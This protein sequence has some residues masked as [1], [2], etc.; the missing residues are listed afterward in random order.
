MPDSAVPLLV[1]CTV[2]VLEPPQGARPLLEELGTTLAVRVTLCP[3]VMLEALGDTSVV[4][5][6]C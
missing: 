6:T 4:V 3:E 1:N 2:P 5:E